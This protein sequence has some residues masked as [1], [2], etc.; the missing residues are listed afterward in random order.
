MVITT[1]RIYE[2]PSHLD[3]LRVLVDGIWP[4]GMRQE[5]ARID[6]WWKEIAPSA[7]LRK[8]YGHDTARWEGFKRKYRQELQEKEA[9][10][11]NF[12]DDIRGKE[13]V[14]ILFG[15]RDKKHNQAIVLKEYL[16]EVVAS[17][18]LA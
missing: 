10:V 14:T 4:R 3:G 1:K 13:R 12:L 11:R 16:D 6:K 7:A 2:S 15:A 9:E 5:D 18:K 8:W 17:G